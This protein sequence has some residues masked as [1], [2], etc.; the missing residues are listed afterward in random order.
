[1]PRPT[2][3]GCTKIDTPLL[4]SLIFNPA[5]ETFQQLQYLPPFALDIIR[6]CIWLVLLVVIFVPLERLFAQKQQKIFRKGFLTDLGYYFISSLLPTHILAVPMAALAWG[7]HYFVPFGLHQWVGGLP[8]WERF[9]GAL[10]IGEFGTYWGHRWMHQVPLLWRF[11]AIHH[12]AEQIDWLV[13]TRA[14]PVDMIFTRLCGFIPMYVFGLVQ[15]IGN[16]VDLVPL[17]VMIVGITWG[18]FIH[19][20]L[21]W[22]FGWLEWFISTPAFHHWHH[23]NDEQTLLNKNF[24]AMIPWV[25]KIF[26]TFYLPKNQL[27]EKYGIDGPM[28]ATLYGQ[29]LQPFAYQKDNN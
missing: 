11:H 28:A 3:T 2:M 22:R 17:L 20:N 26:G 6:L 9:I 8:T 19:A 7:L 1:M 25:D 10:I 4:I 21:S 14:H 5:M 15:P 29:L 24:S 13:N 18:F 12:S 27:P 16:T 23:T